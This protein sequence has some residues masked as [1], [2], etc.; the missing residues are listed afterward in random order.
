MYSLLS[1]R[2]VDGTHFYYDRNLIW[3]S[4]LRCATCHDN[5]HTTLLWNKLWLACRNTCC[6][7][8][9]HTMHA[10]LSLIIAN[11]PTYSLHHARY[12]VSCPLKPN[13]EGHVTSTVFLQKS[14]FN[15]C[16]EGLKRSPIKTC[17]LWHEKCY[18]ERYYVLVGMEYRNI[19]YKWYK[20]WIPPNII[21]LPH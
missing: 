12:H 11:W 13:Q 15:M 4:T 1:C 16:C 2:C 14:H 19:R 21:Y 17:V 9:I 3:A 8:M 7:T 6:H 18:C 5:E 10:N 20:P